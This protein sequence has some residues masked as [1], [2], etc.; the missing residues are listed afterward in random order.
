MC[1]MNHCD[2]SSFNGGVA[3]SRTPLVYDVITDLDKPITTRQAEPATSATLLSNLPEAATSS[4]TL[5]FRDDAPTMKEH[6]TKSY[7]RHFVTA[8]MTS[9]GPTALRCP[10]NHGRSSMFAALKHIALLRISC[11]LRTILFPHNVTC[12]ISRSTFTQT[13]ASGKLLDV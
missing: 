11:C 6:N 5:V 13:T 2:Y 4:E 1:Q 8:E 9:S 7:Q 12:P 10:W 3:Q